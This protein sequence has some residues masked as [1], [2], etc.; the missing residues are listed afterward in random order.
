MKCLNC[1]K[2]LNENQKKFCSRSCSCSFNNRNRKMNDITKD[3]IRNSLKTYRKENPYPNNRTYIITTCPVCNNSF[4]YYKY[5]SMKKQI[6][7]SSECF[8]QDVANGYV[9]STKPKFGGY[10]KGSGRGKSGWYKG[11]W[12][13][14]SYELAYVIYNINHNITFKRNTDKFPYIHQKIKSYYL[15]D[16]IENDIYIEIKGFLTDR[17]KSKID[18]FP[19]NKKIKLLMKKDLSQHFKYVLNVYG[20]DFISLYE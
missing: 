19:D 7:C 16:F 8:Q 14:S 18:Q 9:Y 17:D 13:D 5:P 20:E 2:S 12:C 4:C 1:Q 11:Y 6:F 15:P 3:K 10:R